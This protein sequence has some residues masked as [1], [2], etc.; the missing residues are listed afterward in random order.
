MVQLV[1]AMLFLFSV[2][3]F[4]GDGPLARVMAV[5]PG[6]AA[7]SYEVTLKVEKGSFYNDTDIEVLSAAGKAPAKLKL[8]SGIE[9]LMKG[10]QVKGTTVTARQSPAVGDYI[11][12]PN[13][14]ANY[15]A[16]Q[17]DVGGVGGAPAQAEAPASKP[18]VPANLTKTTPCP[19]TAQEL[20]AA[21]GIKLVNPR[22]TEMPFSGGILYSCSL[23]EDK[24]FG[25]VSINQ[26]V[27][28]HDVLVSSEKESSKHLAG[29]LIYIPND[30]DLA[31]WQT[32]QG[33]LTGVVLHYIRKGI[34]AEIR[35]SPGHSVMKDRAKVEDL[36]NR[37]LKLRRLP[38]D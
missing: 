23:G 37:V 35:V 5:G 28:P 20:S 32:D 14:Y 4:A 13:R 36:R 15:A 6:K 18:A 9:M 21:L 25:S 31:K 1:I 19:Y 12:E 3:A 30:P 11:S 7:G 10:D 38:L 29:K 33:D 24:G 16:A 8:P 26:T 22:G 17:A 2:E 27:M 34:M